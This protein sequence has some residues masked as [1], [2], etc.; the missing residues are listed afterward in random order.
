MEIRKVSKL[1]QAT[2]SP[3]AATGR[4][5]RIPRIFSIRISQASAAPVD[6]TRQLAI[7]L[8]I[9]HSRMPRR[10][11]VSSVSSP[12]SSRNI[13]IDHRPQIPC[14]DIHDP[15]SPRQARR[16]SP[17]RGHQTTSLR[18][19]VQKDKNWRH[20]ER[21]CRLDDVI[22]SLKP[23]LIV[24]LLRTRANRGHGGY[25]LTSLRDAN[26]RNSLPLTRPMRPGLKPC[27]HNDIQPCDS[28]THLDP[29][30]PMCP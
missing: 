6:P 23:S 16:P 24:V 25:G 26:A 11:S 1:R 9:S 30:M 13:L 7:D 3:Q 12:L 27:R 8:R 19:L 15:K 14:C 29:G 4:E 2:S 21:S 28:M 22:M 20:K 18:G 17:A 10:F 5:T